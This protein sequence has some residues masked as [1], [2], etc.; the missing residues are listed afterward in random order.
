MKKGRSQC[1]KDSYNDVD[2]NIPNTA[3]TVKEINLYEA[4]R[5]KFVRGTWTPLEENDGRRALPPRGI[6]LW[7]GHSDWQCTLAAGFA[8]TRMEVRFWRGN[9]LFGEILGWKW[10]IRSRANSYKGQSVCRFNKKMV[11]VG[12]VDIKPSHPESIVAC[13]LPN[14]DSSIVSHF[15][16]E[17]PL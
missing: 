7:C 11:A 13:F 16:L 6:G 4:L 2:A 1:Y 5:N 17:W 3:F 15:I 9:G 12:C 14:T 8:L 10:I